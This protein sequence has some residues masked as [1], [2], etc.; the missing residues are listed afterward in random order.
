MRADLLPIFAQYYTESESARPPGGFPSMER[1]TEE[2]TRGNQLYQQAI[3]DG[4][5]SWTK[6]QYLQQCLP[7]YHRAFQFAKNEDD[8]AS[9]KK[10]LGHAY[11]HMAGTFEL[12]K[13]EMGRQNH[14]MLQAIKS[15]NVASA[16]GK[17]CKTEQWLLGISH[18]IEVCVTAIEATVALIRDQREKL[19]LLREV[20][21][22]VQDGFMKAKW[23]LKLGET[24]FNAG[25]I[26]YENKEFDECHRFMADC[27]E[28]FE[29]AIKHSVDDIQICE[30]VCDFQDRVYVHLCIVES[31]SLRTQA[32]NLF[33]MHLLNQESVNFDLM[34]DVVDMFKH[35]TL[36][37]RE[38]DIEQEAIGL[39]RLGKIFDLV[40]KLPDKAKGYYKRSFQLA[41]ALFPRTFNTKDWYKDCSQAVER[42]QREAVLRDE[43]SWQEERKPFLVELQSEL[44]AL[45]EAS[46]NGYVALLKYVY[47]TYPPKNPNHILTGD[48][49]TK[50]A[51]KMA[52][53]HYHTDKLNKVEDTK[54]YVLC[55]EIC[56]LLSQKYEQLKAAE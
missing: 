1:S 51:V 55:E 7:F 27:H 45:A 47:S 37:V 2:R 26:A 25:V 19:M 23:Y 21:N 10:N 14:F 18:H 17:L 56:K 40:L 38:Q 49:K 34:W 5:P 41:T 22:T 29:E 13:T 4:I 30:A 11:R 52:L 46:E 54:W 36:L 43:Y 35:C 8:K 16:W 20:A 15:F 32:E 42:Y 24:T 3:S 9:A 50:K 53:L 44:N 33:R 6:Q 39:S 12:T 48:G 28:P 31:V